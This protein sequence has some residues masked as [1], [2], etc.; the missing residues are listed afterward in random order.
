MDKS[1]EIVDRLTPSHIEEELPS[2]TEDLKAEV[3]AS[4]NP[5]PKEHD[6]SVKLK[7]NREYPFDFKWTSPN[8]KVWEGKFKNKILTIANRQNM[9]LTMARFGGGM[10]TES[11][12]ALTNE[13]NI[14]IAH[15]MFSLVEKPEW[16]NDLRELN[17]I[18]LI[19]AIY[20]EVDSH[21]STFFGH[22]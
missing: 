3:E 1:Q 8:G 18:A 15:M 20:A 17:E 14:I 7:A 2:S 21:E 5:T 6:R 12:D 13:I 10:P 22:R 19:Q 16:A 11:I 9:G 4:T